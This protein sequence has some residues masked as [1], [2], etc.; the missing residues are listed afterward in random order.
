MKYYKGIWKSEYIHGFVYTCYQSINKSGLIV[1]SVYF[2]IAGNLIYDGINYSFNLF[3][4]SSWK[5]EEITEE[6][7][8]IH[9]I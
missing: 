4:K 5:T 7:F 6:E 2:D 8:F 9:C 3:C 1:R